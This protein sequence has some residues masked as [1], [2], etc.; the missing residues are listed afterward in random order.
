MYTCEKKNKPQL[1]D[2]RNKLSDIEK[3]QNKTKTKKKEEKY[4]YIYEFPAR[5]KKISA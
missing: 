3:I 2:I 4:I 5:E 1:H